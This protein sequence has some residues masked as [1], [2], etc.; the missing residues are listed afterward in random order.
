MDEKRICFIVC[1]NQE[2]YYRECEQYIQHLI[3]PEGYQVEILAVYDAK[4]MAAGYNEA[5]RAS[6]A[7]YKVYLHQDVFLIYPNLIQELLEKFQNS[8]VGMLGVIGC[9]KLPESGIMWETERVGNLDT[10]LFGERNQLLNQEESKDRIVDAIDGVFM[11]TQYDIPWR[12]DLFQNWDFY[13]VSQCKEFQRAGYDVVVPYMSE[14]W[15][16]HDDGILNLTNYNANR[17]IFIKEY[18]AK[19]ELGESR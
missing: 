2:Q 5:M 1:V 11:A 8:K 14:T 18:M 13:D 3:V 17:E 7:K 4:S 16:I 9:E 19:Y 6:D 15:C 10:I 12:E